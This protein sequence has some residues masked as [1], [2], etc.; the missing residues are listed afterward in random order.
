MIQI[1]QLSKSY[2]DFLILNIKDFE[3]NEG[4]HWIQGVNGA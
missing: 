4:L 3:I 1:P 2:G